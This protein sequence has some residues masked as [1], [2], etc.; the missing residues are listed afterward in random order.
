MKV[1]HIS[2]SLFGADGKSSQL[3]S[4]FLDQLQ[5]RHPDARVISRDL[6]RDP[7]PHL[8]AA[9][10]Q[11]NITPPEDRDEQQQALAR[12]A[13]TLVQELLECDLLVLSVPMYNFGIPSTLKAWID[14][15]ARAGTTFKYTENGPVGLVQGK[16]AYVLG[17]RGGAYQGTPNDTQTPYLQTFLGFLG[18]TD[19]TFV[20]AEKLN[21]QPDQVPE[22]LDQ[23]KAE[24]DQLLQD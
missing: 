12:R 1:L 6:A 19:V 18:I 8:D 4:H 2:S 9:T 14:N 11:A 17:A 22:I 3:A 23:A 16:K 15:V 10:F 5:A 13:D 20:L 24:I 7:I 21:M